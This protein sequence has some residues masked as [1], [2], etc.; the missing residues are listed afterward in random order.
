MKRA[1]FGT[2]LFLVGSIGFLIL[3]LYLSQYPCIY[4]GIGGTYGSLLGRDLMFPYIVFCA[5]G[6]IGLV[7]CVY[8]AF[9]RE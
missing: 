3:R 4:N 1:H 9:I 7:I 2:M 5:F 6:L 8:E